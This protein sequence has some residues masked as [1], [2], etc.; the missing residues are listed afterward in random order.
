ML[1]LLKGHGLP[2]CDLLTIY[3]GYIRPILEYAAPVWNSGLT[4]NQCERLERVQRRALRI[5]FGHDY[6]HYDKVLQ[7]SSLT[8]L[9]DRREVLCLSFITKT[10]KT[11]SQFTQFMPPL[12]SKSRSL[13]NSKKVR[14][15]RCKTKRMFESALPYR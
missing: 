9:E 13:S 5:A 14:E 1:R 7:E 8:S 6:T 3:L 15:I 11:T 10:L 2:S 4:R 12:P